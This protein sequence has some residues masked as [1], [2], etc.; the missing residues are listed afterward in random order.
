LRVVI[1][2]V[3]TKVPSF[4]LFVNPVLM[5]YLGLVVGSVVLLDVYHIEKSDKEDRCVQS[6]GSRSRKYTECVFH[7]QRILRAIL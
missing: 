2:I 5:K 6:S 4:H 1:S 3:W 7:V